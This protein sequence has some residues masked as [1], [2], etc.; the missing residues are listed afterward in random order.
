MLQTTGR[1]LEFR[2]VEH[3]DFIIGIAGPELVVV[4]LVLLLVPLL[5]WWLFRNRRTDSVMRLIAFIAL[6]EIALLMIAVA[7][8]LAGA[9]E[10]AAPRSGEFL[11]TIG[12][13]WWWLPLALVGPLLLIVWWARKRPRRPPS[14]S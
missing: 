6:Y 7:S 13:P 12:M 9:R 11:D 4:L 3:T 5:A 1:P 2:P 14:D 8:L 10:A